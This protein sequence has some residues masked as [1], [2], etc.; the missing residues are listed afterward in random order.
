MTHLQTNKDVLAH[1]DEAENR[2]YL[3]GHLENTGTGVKIT[4]NESDPV[5]VQEKVDFDAIMKENPASRVFFRKDWDNQDARAAQ[6]EKQGLSKDMRLIGAGGIVSVQIGNEKPQTIL[7]EKT[8]GPSKGR[9]AQASGVSDKDPLQIMWS[10]I[11][12]ETGV[13]VIDEKA[14]RLS[15]V[16]IEPPAGSL[17]GKD[18]EGFMDRMEQEKLDQ[19]D[20]IKAQLPTKYKD[21]EI[22]TARMNVIVSP[23]DAAYLKDV[24]VSLPGQADK[25]VKAIVS[26]SDKTANV[27]I[28]NPVR[29]NLPAGTKIICVDPEEFQ[30][31]VQLFT[32]D[33][34]LTQDF[35]DNK[36]SVPMRPYL[37]EAMKAELNV[38]PQVLDSTSC[39]GSNLDKGLKTVGP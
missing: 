36:S 15:L 25:T 16:L 2:F 19:I 32:R 27:N 23:E 17:Q 24:T 5:V 6:V 8:A 38:K 21:W 39:G 18:L 9:M 4:V 11:A 37:E 7:F 22:R 1:P 33:Q 31:P 10:E 30:R 20:N 29:L 35:I 13:L 34:M 14:K 26:D 12:E 3:L 28:L